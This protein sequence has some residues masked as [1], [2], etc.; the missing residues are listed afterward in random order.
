MATLFCTSYLDLITPHLFVEYKQKGA[1]NLIR[2]NIYTEI[3]ASCK[4]MTKISLLESIELI[5]MFHKLVSCL[6]LL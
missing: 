3:I 6:L 4:T 5:A 2:V 1:R